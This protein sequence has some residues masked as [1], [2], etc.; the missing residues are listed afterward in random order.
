MTK[1][2]TGIQ[3]FSEIREDN[4][5]YVDKTK[6]IYNL[7]ENGKYYFLSRPRRFGKS[8]LIDTI[9]ELFKGS[10]EYFKGLFIYDKWDWT[11]KYPVIN[12]NFGSGDYSSSNNLKNGIS[13]F[14]VDI[15]DDFNIKINIS[16]NLKQLI[17]QVYKTFNQK[18]V[19]L[20]DEYDKPIIDVLTNLEVAKQNRLI[21]G[22]FYSAIKA[23]DKYVK[24]AMLTGVSKF[25]KINLFSNLNNFTDITIDKEYGTITGY[26]QNDLE[27][28]FK[29]HLVG[30]DMSKIKQWYNGYN[31]FSEPIYNPF[32]ILVFISKK[33]I[34]DNYWWETGN[35]TFLI[36][37]LKKS[38]FYIPDLSNLVVTK[39]MLNAFDVDKI[40]LIA[41]LWQTGYLTF[42]KMEQFDSGIE[43]T[44]K[45]PNLEIKNSL[46]NLFLSYL[47][48]ADIWLPKKSEIHNIISKKDIDSFI[49]SLKSLFSTIPY[50]NYV[51]NEIANY[52]GY[53]SSVIY[54]FLSSL[55]YDTVAEDVTNRG[56]I[57][58][59]LKTKSAIFIF[60]FKVDLKE[61]AIKQI[62][63]RKYYE[64]YQV[65]NK[66]IYIIGIN[67]DSESKN[68]LEYKW[69]KI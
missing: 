8:L 69:E 20:I 65:E 6:D 50:N 57:D 49:S 61:E 54:T 42:E 22:S 23:S 60:E 47:T 53:Y 3:T 55:G 16:L 21:L 66:D 63:D 62:K 19:I 29:E 24:F 33:Y 1:L 28:T 30:V 14:L 43:Y 36:D 56:R 44:M 46:N 2:P 25:S 7:I 12:I 48:G 32:D 68:I 67:F 9:S 40:D 39:E 10:K 41:L 37:I 17:K 35:P 5:A 52:E 38:R 13:E 64:K 18:V 15:A 34:F 59:T 4:Y 45:I 31:Y 51:K 58:L 11:V 26:T 27:T